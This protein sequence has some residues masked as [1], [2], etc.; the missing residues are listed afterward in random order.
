MSKREKLDVAKTIANKIKSGELS[1]DEVINTITDHDLLSSI[2]LC[3]AGPGVGTKIADRHK[4]KRVLYSYAHAQEDRLKKFITVSMTGFVQ[5]CLDDYD[6]P[7]FRCDLMREDTPE[8]QAVFSRNM[9][10]ARR[11][12]IKT[13]IDN[14]SE[15]LVVEYLYALANC[16]YA[17]EDGVTDTLELTNRL[18]ECKKAIQQ[19]KV[20]RRYKGLPKI[21]VPKS[22]PSYEFNADDIELIRRNTREE[23]GVKATREDK[24]RKYKEFVAEFMDFY[25]RYN[26]DNHSR[27]CYSSKSSGGQSLEQYRNVKEREYGFSLVPP[28]DTLVNFDR[29]MADNYH[30]LQQA[31]KDIYNNHYD[32]FDNAVL[33]YDVIT[34]SSED[35]FRDK[36][37]KFEEDNN[38][39][40]VGN[41][42]SGKMWTWNIFA[43][44]PERFTSLSDVSRNDLFNSLNLKGKADRLDA[45]KIMQKRAEKAKMAIDFTDED[46]KEKNKLES[47]EL[48]KGLTNMGVT[49][50]DRLTDDEYINIEDLPS[51]MIDDDNANRTEVDNVV[52]IK[53]AGRFNRNLVEI[54]KFSFLN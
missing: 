54:K 45:K 1:A 47:A 14:E 6:P 21:N 8:F 49:S 18:K 37:K 29:Y 35:E 53:R 46:I 16:T 2:R 12:A 19:S 7:S 41:V 17:A 24:L 9:K 40:I 4:N 20:P 39:I 11:M 22:L 30:H 52:P 10:E 28:I 38:G 23:L 3:L 44:T 33:F 15:P 43:D 48:N 34:G 36:I 50:I 5:R 51:D 32:T 13:L 26:P 27:A 25:F 31:S 42:R